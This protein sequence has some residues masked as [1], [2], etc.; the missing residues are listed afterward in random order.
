MDVGE[1]V[2]LL[3]AS[4]SDTRQRRW[5]QD[6]VGRQVFGLRAGRAERWGLE[7]GDEVTGCVLSGAGRREVWHSEGK[8]E[9]FYRVGDAIG[10]CFGNENFV[11]AIV[12]HGRSNV[13]AWGAVGGPGSSLVG[14]LVRNDSDAGR[15]KRSAIVVEVAK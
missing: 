1:L 4:P 6:G 7:C 8:R 12:V 14:F 10:V 2:R 11:A 13:P 5:R 3:R 9:E 15:G